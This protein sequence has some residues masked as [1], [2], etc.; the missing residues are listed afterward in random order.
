MKKN[1]PIILFTYKSHFYN[2]NVHSVFILSREKF[3]ANTCVFPL[4]QIILNSGGLL[5]YF[6]FVWHAWITFFK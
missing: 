6:V 3:I 1:L 4:L 5:G 2:Q